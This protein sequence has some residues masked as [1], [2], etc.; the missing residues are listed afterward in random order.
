MLTLSPR[1][2]RRRWRRGTRLV[3]VLMALA[4][5]AVG[6]LA[7]TF[8]QVWRATGGDDPRPAD[9]IVVLGAAQYD[10]APSP[11]LQRRLD[12]AHQLYADGWADLI[13][14]TGANQEGDRF[15]QGYAGY[16]YLRSLGV[17]DEAILV[18]VDGTDTYEELAAT[19]NQLRARELESVLLVTDPYHALRV[20]QV[21]AE[22]GLDA[23]V[24]PT[25]GGVSLGRL[26]RETVA[27]AVGR[28]VGYRRLHTW[29]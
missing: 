25:G 9:A 2:W 27:V 14:T 26:G 21:A 13:V 28:L 19:A 4:V 23:T 7:V 20:E 24:T 12:A 3:L 15:T 11:V 22:V 17:P 29:L 6:Y 1:T 10:G 16:R 18:V 5:V 8:V